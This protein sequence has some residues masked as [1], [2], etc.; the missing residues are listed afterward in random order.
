MKN[1]T[2]ICLLVNLQLAF[3]QIPVT[4]HY[5]EDWELTQPDSGVFYRTCIFDTLNFFF[6]GDVKDFTKNNRMLMQGHYKGGVKNGLFTFFYENGQI[7][8]VGN[9]LHNQ[10]WGKWKYF[11][12]DGLPKQEVTFDDKGFFINFFID[13]TGNK[14]LDNGTGGWYD[15]YK[16]HQM[17]HSVIVRGAFFE[18]KKTGDW[19]CLLENGEYVYKEKFKNGVF[20]K[21]FLTTPSGGKGVENFA[22][23]QNKLL[24]HFKLEVME[25]F[26]REPTVTREDYP[27]LGFL[28]TKSLT[29]STG[30]IFHVV[31]DSAYPVGGMQGFYKHIGQVLQYPREARKRGIQGK[32]LV[33]FIVNTDGSLSD[34]KT[35]KGIGGG[36]DEEAER[37]IKTCPPWIP[38]KVKGRPVKQK[39]VVPITFNIN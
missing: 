36:C 39:Y 25:L 1:L 26:E 18:G 29:D 19:E 14:T 24:P 11:Y 15:I 35:I 16:E 17:P 10:Q 28:E 12:S 3:G 21:G 9:F 22:E 27:F 23:I 32:V 7:E 34:V 13:S 37:V 31:E 2:I 33:E 6:E 4:F 5:N 8:S 38:G 30:Q 20:K